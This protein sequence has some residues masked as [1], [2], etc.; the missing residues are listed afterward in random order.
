GLIAYIVGDNE[1][2]PR[3]LRAQLNEHLPE[4][5]LPSAY[6]FLPSLPITTNGKLDRSAL[7]LPDDSA[8]VKSVYE[9]PQGEIEE[10]L[11]KIW[12][13]LLNVEHVSRLDNFFELG[14]HS[15]MAVQLISQI[16]H[17]LKIELPIA[18]VFVNATLLDLAK[19]LGISE[20]VLENKLMT[21][22][23][24]LEELEW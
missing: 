2:S 14:G 3:T 19:N 22:S 15:L 24:S 9:E 7:P 10:T 4:Y 23:E 12:S 6:V 17:Q 20:L 16:R 21:E 13:Q 5:M 18:D 8:Y 11:A 1:D